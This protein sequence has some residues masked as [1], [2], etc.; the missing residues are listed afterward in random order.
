MEPIF[1]PHRAHQVK[2][3]PRRGRLARIPSLNNR[4]AQDMA[5]LLISAIAAAL[6]TGAL[7][8]L[9]MMST[10]VYAETASADGLESAA[11]K[12]AATDRFYPARAVP[13]GDT[14]PIP[15]SDPHGLELPPICTCDRLLAMPN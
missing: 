7:A 5:S 4:D 9:I 11:H 1:P 12:T 14:A 13:G 10:P 3:V 6:T 8:T 15:F 2:T